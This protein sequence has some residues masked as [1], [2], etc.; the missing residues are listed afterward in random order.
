MIKTSPRATRALT[1]KANSGVR[2]KVVLDIN[3]VTAFV[4]CFELDK[5][6]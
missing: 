1:L 5:R 4:P 3:V 2:L 6:V